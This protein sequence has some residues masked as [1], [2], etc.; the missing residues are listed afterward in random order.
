MHQT[1]DRKRPGLPNAQA[2]A[3]RFEPRQ[4]DRAFAGEELVLK[5]APLITEVM[6]FGFCLESTRMAGGEWSL[7]RRPWM[8]LRVPLSLSV[9]PFSCCPP[10]S[11][12][13]AR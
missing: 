12:S 1:R 8:I 7:K 13:H 6:N 2:E 11:S 3:G 10:R 4:G 9:V 5:L